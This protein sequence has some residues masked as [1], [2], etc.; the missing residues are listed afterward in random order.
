[1]QRQKWQKGRG[2][3]RRQSGWRRG[4]QFDSHLHKILV[5][6]ERSVVKRVH[7]LRSQQRHHVRS[8]HVRGG[9]ELE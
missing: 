2:W 3:S 8:V 9:E 6:E 5:R 1:M 7:A 4:A